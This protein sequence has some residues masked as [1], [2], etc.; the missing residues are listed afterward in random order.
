MK[1]MTEVQMGEHYDSMLNECYGEEGLVSIAGH[2]Y[3]VA[4]ALKEVDPTAYR[5]GMADYAD[6]LM[7]DGYEIEGWN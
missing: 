3:E 7:A 1:K 4:N 2:R 6:N 5:V